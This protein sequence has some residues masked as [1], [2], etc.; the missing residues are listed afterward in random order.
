MD[1]SIEMRV[2]KRNGLLEDLSFDKILNRIRKLGQE[3][4]LYINYQSMITCKVCLRSYTKNY[5]SSDN[6]LDDN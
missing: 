1:N 5:L 4:K 2:I 3:A 6:T